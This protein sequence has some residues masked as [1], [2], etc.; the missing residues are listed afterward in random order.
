[1]DP[2]S[3][4]GGKPIS[5]RRAALIA[6][7]LAAGV[8]SLARFSSAIDLGLIQRIAAKSA[9][10]MTPTTVTAWIKLL[11]DVRDLPEGDRLKPVNDFFNRNIRFED[12]QALWG[13][14]DYW[15]TPLETLTA[16]AGDCED[17]GIAKYFSLKIVGIPNARLRLIYVKAQ[18]G[19]PSSG[20]SQAHMVLAYY[21]APDSEPLVLDNLISEIR[22]ASRR[23]DLSPVFSFNSDGIWAGV[24]ANQ[25]VG[26]T[27][28]LSRWRDLLVRARNE[29]FD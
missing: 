19:G 15:A 28:R 7:V 11:A 6:V 14:P 26:D 5:L 23:P 18:L 8:F 17:F 9:R 2:S 1:M 4:K 27:S 22:P 25:A 24:G 21:A 29:G 10:G 20:I 13:Q 12:D 16:G 3:P